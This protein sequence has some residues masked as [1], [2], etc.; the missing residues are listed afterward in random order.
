MK[1]VHSN[2]AHK[3][4]RGDDSMIVKEMYVGKT[5]VLIDNSFICKTP[6]EREKVD[7]EIAMAA[8]A[9]IDELIERGEAV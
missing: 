4:H 1:V 2:L 8:W 6:E 9:I 3:I 7:R 5:K